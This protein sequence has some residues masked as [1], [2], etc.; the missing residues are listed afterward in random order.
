M[1]HGVVTLSVSVLVWVA[2][3]RGCCFLSF[4]SRYQLRVVV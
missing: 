3:G 4:P 2:K 1:A